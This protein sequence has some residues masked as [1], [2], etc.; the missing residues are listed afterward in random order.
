MASKLNVQV[1]VGLVD[2]LTKPLRAMQRQIEA[3]QRTAQRMAAAGAKAS[4]G[5]LAIAAGLKPA[6]AAFA[7]AEDAAT[8]MK[9]SMMGQGGAVSGSFADM[10]ALAERLGDVMPG[11][12]ADFMRMLTMLRRQGMSA[13]TVLGGTGEAAA[14]LAVMLQMVPEAA[15]EFTAKLQDATGA[16]E[17]DMLSLADTIQRAFYIGVDPSNM[18]GAYA[19]LAP[20]MAAIKQKGLA[21]AQGMAPLIAMLDQASLSGPSAGNALRKV[22]QGAFGL[23]QNADRGLKNSGMRFLKGGE[24]AGLDNMFEQL[25]KL[26][27]LT[28][29]QRL[30]V[31]KD[32]WGDD[33]ETLQALN[34]MIDKGAAGYAEMSDKMR[35]QAALSERMT[36]LLGTLKN[37]WDAATG[38]VTNLAARIG[39]LLAP[40]LKTLTEALGAVV[41]KVKAWID[42]NPELAK[43]IALVVVGLGALLLVIGGLGVVA[44]GIM[45]ALAPLAVLFAALISPVGLVTAAIIALSAGFL[46][47]RE[48]GVEAVVNGVIWI[49][50][51]FNGLIRYFDGFGTMLYKVGG[52]LMD[53]LWR[54]ISEKFESIKAGIYG[55]VD[56]ITGIFRSETETHSPSRV[57]AVLGADLMRGLEVGIAATARLPM[58]AMRSAA[59]AVALGASVTAMP[60]AASLGGQGTAGAPI[61]IITNVTIQAP[62]G[63]DAQGLADLVRQA[64]AK[65]TSQ[66]AGRLGALYDSTDGM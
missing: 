39:E 53:G 65:S 52:A 49:E 30:D 47:F 55:I 19:S 22:F 18:L 57:F 9:L 51:K 24:F 32:I 27:K 16:T 29:E 20:A 45:F 62:A 5:G 7:E 8:R 64:V 26:R 35:E 28:T 15:A 63:T 60:S 2:R 23:A 33:S 25:K 10:A 50:E 59:G 6:I 54:G 43:V 17:K 37:M 11:T 41:T 46:Y 58:A 48:A 21:G 3:V 66:A 31:M 13:A 38:S 36:T 4:A 12:T 42:A 14:N 40:E 44:G 1:V 34:T 56:S 61:S